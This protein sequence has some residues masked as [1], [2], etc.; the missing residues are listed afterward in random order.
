MQEHPYCEIC[1]K[2]GKHAF[3]VQLDHIIPLFKGGD[4]WDD[5][6]WQALCEPCHDEK[7]RREKRQIIG[8]DQFGN[9][10]GAVKINL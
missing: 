3:S 9:P 6:N 8:A 1:L 4:L 7:S 5:A 2:D 10:L